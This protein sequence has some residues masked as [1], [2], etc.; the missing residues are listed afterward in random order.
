MDFLAL[1]FLGVL[2]ALVVNESFWLDVA[3]SE[4]L[5]PISL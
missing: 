2:G 4:A 1:S 3:F 5:R